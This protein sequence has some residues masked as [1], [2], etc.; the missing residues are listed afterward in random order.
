MKTVICL[1]FSLFLYLS[2]MVPASARPA[3]ENR[4]DAGGDDYLEALHSELVR[5]LG[6]PAENE[7][8]RKLQ[9]EAVVRSN[10]CFEAMACYYSIRHARYS[11][12]VS[13]ATRCIEKLDSLAHKQKSYLL[14]L[15]AGRKLLVE[16]YSMQ[17]D[18]ELSLLEAKNMYEEAEKTDCLPCMAIARQSLASV[19]MTTGQHQEA[20]K[21]LSSIHLAEFTQPGWKEFIRQNTYLLFIKT[22]LTM[23]RPDKA[24]PYFEQLDQLLAHSG[25]S[26]EHAILDKLVNT[27]TLFYYHSLQVLY[28]IQKKN[29]PEARKHLD[30]IDRNFPA[31]DYPAY[32]VLRYRVYAD[33]YMANGQFEETL[34]I[35]DT[36]LPLLE[37]NSRFYLA[38]LLNQADLYK[39]TGNPKKAFDA[40]L[41]Y[42][43]LKDSVEQDRYI[44][45]INQYKT[46]LQAAQNETENEQLR[47]KSFTLYY[48]I[49][50]LLLSLVILC[51]LLFVNRHLKK[52]LILAKEQSERSDRL[53][54]AFLA[55]M[56]HEIRTP[57]NAIAGFSQLLADEDDPEISR[58]YIHIIKGNNELLVNLLNDVL[59]ISKIESDTLTFHYTDVFLPALISELYDTVRL[60]VHEPVQLIKEATPA[61][62]IRTDRNRLIQILSNLLSNSIKHTSEGTIKIGY[63]AIDNNQVRFY[64]T[65]T[66][67]GIPR[68]MLSHIFARFVQAV[69]T[70]TKG[71]GLGLALCKGFVQQ[72]GGE[73]GVVSEEGKGST[74]WFTLPGRR[75]A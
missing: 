10:A 14:L 5:S 24:S 29:L 9:Q 7:A 72:M 75:E 68:E 41:H 2:G 45:Q 13:E 21:Q 12:S 57:L 33:Y 22:H 42:I 20:L 36:L 18:L 44:R 65:D 16:L 4:S 59:D 56:N 66:G 49:F 23:R 6:T 69:E 34:K 43:H 67:K 1:L 25:K 48:L 71:V 28:H 30:W 38:T 8:I 54:S 51:V 58:Q 60:Q 32:H 15:F 61:L 52:K 46:Q 27:H 47:K 73:I 70:H 31:M 11:L 74:F 50:S 64:V 37:H 40:Y 39:R 55:N 53:K 3:L 62:S 19:Y 63:E 35:W 17:G 26:K